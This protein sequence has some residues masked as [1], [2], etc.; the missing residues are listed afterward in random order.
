MSTNEQDFNE[1]KWTTLQR[2]KVYKYFLISLRIFEE[3]FRNWV[4][5]GHSIV[6]GLCHVGCNY[7]ALKFY[8]RMPIVHYFFYPTLSF[9]MFVFEAI[10]YSKAASVF[11]YSE[12]FIDSWRKADADHL[13]YRKF[14][15]KSLNGL[16][17]LRIENGDCF[18]YTKK[19]VMTFFGILINTTINVLLMYP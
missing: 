5:P 1:H 19:T 7:A 10:A 14:V 3:C 8:S 15:Q 4:I 12:L 9:A 2:I 17:Q 6:V 16:R 18:F 11:E 13:R